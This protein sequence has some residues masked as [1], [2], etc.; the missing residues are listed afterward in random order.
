MFRNSALY[1]LFFLLLP[2]SAPAAP[3]ITCH[4]F[5]DR[6]YDPARPGAADPYF[7]ATTQNTFFATAFGTSKKN[8]VRK[9]QQ[10]AASEDLWVAFWVGQKSGTDPEALLKAKKDSVTWKAALASL[11]IT[12]GILGARF[13]AALNGEGSAPLDQV[14]VDELFLRFRLLGEADLVTLRQAGVSNQELI[15]STLIGLR[16]KRPPG[17]IVRG[18][19][20]D[21]KSWGELLTAGGID[22][23]N[24]QQD[25][26]T[27]LR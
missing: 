12:P 17:E 5:T 4:C 26:S 20:V 27:M 11:S 13:S 22:I 16:S 14:A 8:L 21:G 2:L 24:I 18:A 7:L 15:I 10:G 25:F 6:S 3:T 19:K 1:L 9:K 23:T